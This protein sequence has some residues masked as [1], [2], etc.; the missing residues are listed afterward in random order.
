MVERLLQSACLAPSAGNVQPWR[1]YVIRGDD[2]KAQ[3]ASAALGQAFVSQAPVVIVVCAD[4]VAHASVY[5]KRG[6]ELYS[7]QDCAA[8]VENILLAATAMGLGSCWV[9]AFREDQAASALG[10]PSD[11]RPL[12][13]IPLG[14]AAREGSQPR[15]V[16]HQGVTTYM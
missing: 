2:L 3:L 9:G 4:L 15:K 7:I 6:V 11:I 10:L 8:A 12:A 5:G 16:S 1:F 13:M 14:Y